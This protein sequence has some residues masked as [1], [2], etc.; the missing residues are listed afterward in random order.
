MHRHS[1]VVTAII[2]L[3]FAAP[4]SAQR[5]GRGGGPEAAATPGAPRFRYMGPQP[6]GRISAV[7][8]VP[9][10]PNVY[11]LGAAS[12]G[13]WKSTDGGQTFVPIFDEEPVMAIG[14]LALAPT[15]PNT[16]W[17]GTGEAW[18]IRDIDVMGDGVYKSTD[19]GKTWQHMGLDA[20]GRIGRIVVSP[21]D[22]QT[23]YV[24]A[25]GMTNGPQEERGVFK[26]NDGGATWKRVLFVNP[27]TGCSGLAVDPNDP[28]TMLAGTW[29]VLMHTWGEFSGTWDGYKGVP[30]SGVYI[31]HDAGETW[32]KIE[33]GMPKPP[34]GKIDVAIAPSD[35]KR[36][37][38]L[39]QT[40]DQGSLWRSDDGGVTWSDVSW[41]RDLIGRAGYYIRLAV[42]PTNPDD[43]LVTNSSF[44]RSSDGGKTFD[45]GR[46]ANGGGGGGFG[47]GAGRGA[48]CGDCHDIWMDPKIPNRFVLTDDAGA[49]ISTGDSKNPVIT[50]HLPIGQMYHVATDDRAP[51]WLYTNRQDN[52]TMRGPSDDQEN[53]GSGVVPGVPQAGGIIGGGGRGGRGGGGGGGG[54]TAAAGGR[55]APPTAGAAAPGGR[56][57]APAAGTAAFAAGGFGGGGRG[58]GSQWQYAIGGCES[59]FTIP[60][61]VD[62]NIVWAS[63][64]AN[65]VTRYDATVGR[66]RSVSPWIHTLD[67]EPNKAKYRCH[68]TPPLAVDPFDGSVYYGCQVIFHTTD[69]G[70][71]WKIISP[72]LS[73]QNPAHIVSSGGIVGDN[74]G[75]FYGDVVFAIAPSPIQRH[76]IWAGTNDGKLW[77]T[78]DGGEHWTDVT[79]NIKGVPPEG[80]ILQISPS[81]FDPATAYVAIDLHLSDDRKPYLFKTNDFGA[82]W[83]K[84]SDTLPTGHPL[85][86]MRSVAEDP[87]HK[88]L[89]FAGTGHAFYYSL[90]DGKSWTKYM[91]GLPA[92][93]VTWITVEKRY[94][95]V[96]ISTYGRGIYI[97]PDI[98]LLE[99]TGQM[100]PAVTANKLFVP[101]V[102]IR[103]ARTGTATFDFGLTSAP[104]GPLTV[105]VDDASGQE[106]RKMP[107]VVHAGLNR[108]TWDLHYDPPSVVALRTTPAENPHIW[109]EPRFVGH[110]TRPVTHWGIETAIREAPIAAPGKYTV[111]FTV[112]GQTLSQPFEIIKDPAIPSSDADLVASTKMQIKVRDDMN[113]AADLTNR[114]EY[115]RRQVE[116]QTKAHQGDAADVKALADL[117]EKLLNVELQLITHSDMQSDD[118]YYPEQYKVYLNL[119]WFGGEIGNGAGDVAG[120]AEY[121][122]TQ[123]E[124][125]VL[126]GIEADLAKA[127]ASYEKVV[128]T[129][130]A[131]FNQAMNGKLTPISVNVPATATPADAAGP[132]DSDSDS[133]SSGSGT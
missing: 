97:L 132:S 10:D 16:V 7:V 41:A 59:G 34:V 49:S 43:V 42:N 107:V 36:M 56:G 108:A 110:D 101:N 122:P 60:D 5:G 72:D 70:Q 86:Y 53:T 92:A 18:A 73:T 98:S 115:A 100:T 96:V 37:Y 44:H 47:P 11:Y 133:D 65:E 28:K 116:D 131:A 67:S 39:I 66:A 121:R 125:E 88:G 24:C 31:S 17:V 102:A 50:V 89:L 22:A 74:L 23:V 6:A 126:A 94:H 78:K 128:S 99:Q 4:L 48:S 104:S 13:V 90:D 25:L 61:P 12:G 32:T 58:G 54:A 84:I 19:A 118:K 75:Q 20:T 129:D 26:S 117:N 30:G 64:Y 130:L 2:C 57:N 91:D 35:G 1:F 51:Y 79:K 68:W 120:G 81:N 77:Y 80:T 109:E 62:T 69:A 15:D 3:F 124:A 45:A 33:N 85:D 113:E 103:Q 76:L 9:G 38:A 123:A 29:Q 63:C 87:N 112:D 105:E 8:G 83:T 95:D 14:A 21:T 93:P 46:G 55:G 40:A 114:L 52:G 127:K 71:S 106:V 111:K 27:W 82:T 119:I